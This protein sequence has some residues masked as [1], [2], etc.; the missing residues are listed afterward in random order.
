MTSHSWEVES[1][2]FR[3]GLAVRKCSSCGAKEVGDFLAFPD[4]STSDVDVPETCEEYSALEVL[5]EG[6]EGLGRR[7]DVLRAR[8][9]QECPKCGTELET[10]SMHERDS[11]NDVTSCPKCKWSFVE[12]EL[13]SYE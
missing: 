1:S 12:S 10:E 13:W 7:A 11:S 9:T 2:S 6:L 5:N 8:E 3:S 4:G